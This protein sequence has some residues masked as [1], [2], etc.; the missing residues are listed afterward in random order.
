MKRILPCLLP[1]AIGLLTTLNT[2]AAGLAPDSLAGKTIIVKTTAP[3]K[4]T[5]VNEFA[6]TTYTNTTTGGYGTY[7]WGLNDA[8]HG[9]LILTNQTPDDSYGDVSTVTLAFKNNYS[10]SLTGV[11]AFAAGGSKVI[12]GTFA[13][14]V[15]PPTVSITSPKANLK[16]SDTNITVTG[17]ASDKV[18]VGAV[19][20]QI[21]NGGWIA[22][23][24][25][26]GYTNWT[27]ANLP[28]VLGA[29]VLQACAVDGSGNIS[30]TNTVKFTGV[31]TTPTGYAPASLA[32]YEATV[33]VTGKNQTIIM[34]WGTNT[35]GQTGT[36]GDTNLDDYCAGTYTYTVT[37]PNTAVITDEDIGMMSWLGTTNDTTINV[38]FTSATAASCT[39]SNANDSG[40]ATLKLSQVSNLVPA[41]LAGKTVEA[42]QKSVLK[43][44]LALANDG[45]FT[46]TNSGGGD[47]GTYTFTQYSP[48]VA[49]L[50]E[51]VT[52]VGDA[53]AEAYDLLDFTSATAGSIVDSFYSNPT[54]GSNP[55]DGGQGTF[56]IK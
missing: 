15:T 54:Y 16:C 23:S 20:V 30:K 32:G 1:V 4:G 6:A 48:T 2:L 14:D 24:T 44:S 18:A 52:D 12:K 7:T 40:S 47:S 3:S 35:W 50:H 41:T 34:T 38:T 33:T 42:Y 13:F 8:S 31:S 55:S 26:N 27:A 53:G 56:K 29:N 5:K 43:M 39:W 19:W 51:V 22:A 17:K 37:G 45:T 25:G 10:G 36:S 21:N 49:I 28:V 46:E 9:V 11:V